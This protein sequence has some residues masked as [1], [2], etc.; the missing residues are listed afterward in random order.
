MWVPNNYEKIYGFWLVELSFAGTVSE[1]RI[2]FEQGATLHLR[3]WKIYPGGVVIGHDV[4]LYHLRKSRWR[5]NCI[6][7][8]VA[9]GRLRRVHQIELFISISTVQL[10]VNYPF[11]ACQEG[12]HWHWQKIFP[13][14]QFQPRT[15]RPTD[16]RWKPPKETT[17]VFVGVENLFEIQ[18]ILKSVGISVNDRFLLA[19]LKCGR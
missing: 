6:S 15:N 14:F 5:E 9:V 1:I 7:L 4:A 11:S 8:T 17:L 10:L 12:D 16:R 2:S 18:L 13:R 19:R 3:N